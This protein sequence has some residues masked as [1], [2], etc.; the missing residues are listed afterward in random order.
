MDACMH[1]DR[2]TDIHIHIYIYR[3]ICI[4]ICIYIYIDIY[5]YICTYT[6]TYTHTHIHTYTHI[7][8]YK[9]T[10]YINFLIP[11]YGILPSCKLTCGESAFSFGK[12]SRTGQFSTSMLVYPRLIFLGCGPDYPPCASRSSKGSAVIAT[13]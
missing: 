4:Y 7:P 2:Q 6:C 1:A 5:T 9:N 12:S 11:I 8:T 10:M 3:C 13:W